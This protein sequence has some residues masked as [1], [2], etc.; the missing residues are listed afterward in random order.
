MD[1]RTERTTTEQGFT[2]TGI[3]IHD[4]KEFASGGAFVSD[5]YLIAYPAGDQRAGHGTL[6]DWQGNVIGSWQEVSHRRAVWFGHSSWMGST[7]Y[8]MRATLTDGRRYAL[9]GYGVNMI[10]KG[11][12]IK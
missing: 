12:R 3:V 6:T 1:Y 11:K 5:A 4:G 10:A 8:Y 7:Y 9:R 2:E